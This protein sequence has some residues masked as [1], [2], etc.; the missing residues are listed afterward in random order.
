M[1]QPPSQDELRASEETGAT[2]PREEST[3]SPGHGATVQPPRA[4][5]LPS[6][7]PRQGKAIAVQPLAQGKD[8]PSTALLSTHS[9]VLIFLNHAPD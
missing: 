7:A 6:T 2:Q 5:P 4:R 3:V 9:H 8:C 1:A